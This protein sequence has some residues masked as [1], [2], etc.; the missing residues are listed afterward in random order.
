MSAPRRQS[1]RGKLGDGAGISQKWGHRRDYMQV[2]Y[3]RVSGKLVIILGTQTEL[4]KNVWRLGSVSAPG[5]SSAMFCP[6]ERQ[7]EF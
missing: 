3:S 7:R 1:L 2:A 6:A 4:L 5:V